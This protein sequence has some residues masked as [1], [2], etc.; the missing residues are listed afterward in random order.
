MRHTIEAAGSRNSCFRR[1]EQAHVNSCQSVTRAF[2]RPVTDDSEPLRPSP[3]SNAAGAKSRDVTRD[4]AGTVATA[5]RRTRL[6]A[7]NQLPGDEWPDSPSTISSPMPLDWTGEESL[8]AEQAAAVKILEPLSVGSE[9]GSAPV[10]R[11]QE[12]VR[13]PLCG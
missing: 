6:R 11:L 8:P 2:A 10:K 3:L 12:S 9:D 5:N 4:R 13:F 7:V 1:T